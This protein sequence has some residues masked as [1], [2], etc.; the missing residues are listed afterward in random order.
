MWKEK[1]LSRT[2]TGHSKCQVLRCKRQD[3][4]SDEGAG[5]REERKESKK[6]EIIT[7]NSTTWEVHYPEVI[8]KL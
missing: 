7:W 3:K 1:T 2:E 4:K 6:K 8:C 5:P